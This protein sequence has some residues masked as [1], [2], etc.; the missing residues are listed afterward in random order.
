MPFKQT[1]LILYGPD[2][3]KH[4][5][6][7]FDNLWRKDLTNAYLVRSTGPINWPFGPFRYF[8]EAEPVMHYFQA[9]HPDSSFSITRYPATFG[10]IEFGFQWFELLC[11]F[12]WLRQAAQQNNAICQRLL[13]FC[14]LMPGDLNT[15]TTRALRTT[16]RLVIG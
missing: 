11:D 7:P 5:R 6:I 10:E 14:A 16:K 2:A 12:N 3:A 15:A 4:W 9:H 13:G 1:A 8:E